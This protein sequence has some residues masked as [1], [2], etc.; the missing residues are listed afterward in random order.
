WD[1]TAHFAY[2]L[3][4][5][6]RGSRPVYALHGPWPFGSAPLSQ[7]QSR[8]PGPPHFVG[9]SEDL[10]ELRPEQ[11][12][13]AR[14]KAAGPALTGIPGSA[15]L[16]GFEL[17][18]EQAGTGEIVGFRA[19]WVLK[20]P[21][22]RAHFGIALGP[23]AV[24]AEYFA[25][26]LVPEGRFIQGFPVLYG[27][28][29]IGVSPEGTVYEQRGQLIIPTNAPEGK[30]QVGVGIGP[31]HAEQYSGWAGVAELRIE[32]RPQPRNGP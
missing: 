9:L 18:R 11:P 20:G 2:Q 16:V 1:R 3:A 19:E 32:A 22:P 31:P 12:E 24:D 5:R 14:E 7:Q 13:L 29:D 30:Y 21:P 6:L 15:E 26:R 8:F 17:E 23:E 4:K 27:L 10:V 25:R 28:H